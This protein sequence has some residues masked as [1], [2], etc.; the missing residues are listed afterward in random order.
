ME[1]VKES[2]V[3][4]FAKPKKKIAI[5]GCSDHKE[6]APYNDPEWELWG[7]NNLFLSLTPEKM[8]GFGRWFEIHMLEKLPNGK[9]QRRRIDNFRGQPVGD[10]IRSL[11][12]IDIPVYMQRRWE[13]I[14]KS[15]AYPLREVIDFVKSD[16]FTNTISYQI[17]LAIMEIEQGNYEPRIGV[18]GVDMAVQSDLMGNA[19]YSHQRPSCEYFLGLAI[20]R[21]INVILPPECDLLKTRFLYGWNEPERTAWD[22]KIDNMLKT[23]N[24]RMNEAGQ[25]E[26]FARSQREQYIGAIQAAKELRR[27]WE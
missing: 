14:P 21:G 6:K 12:N 1:E 17:A 27:V 4:D 20:G 3:L 23:L 19:E 2:K 16:Y 18:W 24:V 7:V 9:I 11:A 22:Q 10:Y 5:V 8:K 15:V 26:S 25:K 13:E